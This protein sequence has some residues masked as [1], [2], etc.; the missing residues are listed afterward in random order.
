MAPSSCVAEPWI[1]PG[2]MRS[3]RCRVRPIRDDRIPDQKVGLPPYGASSRR[4]FPEALFPAGRQHPRRGAIS[5]SVGVD[6]RRFVEEAAGYP[7]ITRS[8]RSTLEKE[9]DH[10]ANRHYRGRHDEGPGGSRI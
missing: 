2:S 3:Q 8:K 5:R 4:T 10:G 9:V 7:V 6:N 1:A